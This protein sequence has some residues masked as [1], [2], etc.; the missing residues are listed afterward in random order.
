MILAGLDNLIM[1]TFLHCAVDEERDER[2]TQR[3]E[4]ERVRARTASTVVGSRAVMHTSSAASS[5]D[6][7]NRIITISAYLRLV[8]SCVFC[9]LSMYASQ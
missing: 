5:N 7:T 6:T 2:L 4:R 1:G 9:V 3:A 8:L